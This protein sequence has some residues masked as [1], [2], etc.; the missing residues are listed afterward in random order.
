MQVEHFRIEAV[1]DKYMLLLHT[2]DR[3]GVIG[4]IGTSL[5]THGINISRMQFGREK[6]EGKSLLLLSTDGPVSSGIIEQMRGLP[7]IISID[8]IE[9]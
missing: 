9:I 8:S 7:H 6:L 2:Y 3:P 1:P 5:G 4:N